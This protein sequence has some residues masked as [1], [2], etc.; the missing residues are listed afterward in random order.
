MYD[1]YQV[2]VILY[3]KVKTGVHL[4]WYMRVPLSNGYREPINLDKF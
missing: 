4:T 2:N 1:I 3:W